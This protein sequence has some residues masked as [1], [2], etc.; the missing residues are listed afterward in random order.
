VVT[1]QQMFEQKKRAAAEVGLGRIVDSH[2]RASTLYTRFT[3]RFGAS[4]SEATM[5]PNPRPGTPL[6]RTNKRL[7]NL[8]RGARTR[9]SSGRANGPGSARGGHPPV[10]FPTVNRFCTAVLCGRAG[11]LSPKTAVFGP[12]REAAEK[13]RKAAVAQ[14]QKLQWEAEERKAG[15]KEAA[16]AAR[17]K[18]EGK[19]PRAVISCVHH[20]VYFLIDFL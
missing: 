18:R 10:A 3:N 15:R 13:R 5:R 4:R 6:D 14:S 9:R 16:V 12:G 20:P 17:A 2:H 7:Q 8:S 11:H 19:Q 1:R